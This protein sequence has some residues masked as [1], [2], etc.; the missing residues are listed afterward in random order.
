MGAKNGCVA[1]Y[2]LKQAK[3]QVCLLLGFIVTWFMRNTNLFVCCAIW[4]S[5]LSLKQYKCNIKEFNRT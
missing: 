2:E 4:C 3:S 1:F 5:N